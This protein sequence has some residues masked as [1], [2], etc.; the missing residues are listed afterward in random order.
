Q[1]IEKGKVEA[2]LYL[3]KE[4]Y[5][6]DALWL[7]ECTMNQLNQVMHLYVCNA[8]YKQLMQVKNAH[9]E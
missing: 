7:Y 1:G 4:K 5:N 9:F 2:L 3:I 6:E 8:N